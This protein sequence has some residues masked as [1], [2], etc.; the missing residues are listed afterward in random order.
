MD[1]GVKFKNGQQK[2]VK[3][4]PMKEKRYRNAKC[5]SAQLQFIW[6]DKCQ[7]RDK[8]TVRCVC[9]FNTFKS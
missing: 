8:L 9:T 4:Q 1:M 5:K 2:S 7:D 6:Q 3:M